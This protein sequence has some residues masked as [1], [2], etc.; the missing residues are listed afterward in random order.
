MS[1][2][3]FYDVVVLN[4]LPKSASL[5][6]AS[7]QETKAR[8]QDGRW[9]FDYVYFTESDQILMMREHEE[10]Y[11]HLKK[12]PRR[13]MLP[14]RLNPYPPAVII[15]RYHRNVSEHQYMDWMHMSCCLE[16][17]NCGNRKSWKSV[18][19]PVVKILNIYGLQVALGACLF[20]LD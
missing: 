3:P 16:R 1:G 14:H 17:Q 15:E 10:I 7:V 5:P 20:S 9:D 11:G 6:V 8:I 18:G 19:E 13:L 2:L 4:Y 12:F